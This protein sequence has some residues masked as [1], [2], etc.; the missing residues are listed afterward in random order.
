MRASDQQRLLA[1]ASLGLLGIAAVLVTPARRSFVAF[2]GVGLCLFAVW[3]LAR[4]G[5]GAAIAVL[6]TAICGIAMTGLAWQ[7]VMPLAVVALTAVAK[8]WPQLGSVRQPRGRVPLWSTVGC[9]AVTP[10]ALTLWL[11]LSESDVSDIVA[12]VPDVGL[13]LLVLGGA[14]FAVVNAVLEELIWR[15]IFQSRLTE[16]FGVPWAI[17]IQAASFGVAHA[18]GVPRG[19]IGVTLAG[20][21]G[22][23]LGVLRARTGGLLAPVLAHVVADATIAYL[24]I[25]LAR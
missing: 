1:V 15:G 14:A 4:P 23:M 2:A 22:G 17:A 18:H 13:P 24:I 19:F 7:G 21:W 11:R 6:A 8:L 3:G 10:V 20:I 12:L 5:P 9:A 16:L 25:S